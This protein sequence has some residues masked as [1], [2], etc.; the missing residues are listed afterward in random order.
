MKVDRLLVDARLATMR[1]GADPYGT[2]APGAIAIAGE[3]IAWVGPVDDLPTGMRGADRIGL[4]GRWVTPGLVDC[5][6][7][8]VYGGNRAHEFELRLGG[9][10]YAEISAAGGGIRSTVA[11]TRSA[12]EAD[13]IQVA[14]PRIDALIAEGATTVE[15]KS[16]YGLSVD[17]ELKMLR[18][19]RA[20]GR[21]RPVTVRTTLLGLHALPAE[22]G[23][24]PDAYAD[25]CAGPMIDAAVAEGLADAVDGFCETIG[26]TV[27][28]TERVF[29]AARARGLPVKLHAEQLSNQHG[30]ALAARFGALS[31]DHLEWLDE[32]GVRAMAAA[33]TVAVL[34]PGAFYFLKETRKPPVDLLRRY[35]VSMAVSTDLNPGSSPLHSPLLAMNMAC[36]LFGLTP[37]EALAG[38]TRIGAAALGM[39]DEA[40]TIE[41]GKRADLCVWEVERPGELAYRIGFNPLHRRLWSGS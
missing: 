2:V 14:R 34:L 41:A 12:S 20:L 8:L 21:M 29:A 36:T 31:A 3:R 26:F 25:L 24:R 16:G 27:A 35:G 33:G 13:L 4:D 10:T 22:Y 11:A 39:A 6:T 37:A 32:D 23:D 18:A 9:A 7:H 30:A 40:G 15:V 5:H 17:H 1:P 19:A 38:M 28:Q